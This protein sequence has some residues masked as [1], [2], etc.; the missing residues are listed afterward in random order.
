V[1]HKGLIYKLIELKVPNYIVQWIFN[2]LEERTFC[3]KINYAISN[4]CPISAGVP[5]GAALSPVMF[6]IYINDIPIMSNKNKEYGLLLA[7]DFIA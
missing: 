1:W 2:F 5:Q 7:D 6:S 4:I 3:I